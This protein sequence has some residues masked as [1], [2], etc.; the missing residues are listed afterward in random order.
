M[1]DKTLTVSNTKLNAT[2][3][4]YTVSWNKAN[5][6]GTPQ[7]NLRY[8]FYA[9]GSSDYL[10]MAIRGICIPASV[11]YP[12]TGICYGSEG[13]Q[14][15]SKHGEGGLMHVGKLDTNSVS[16]AWYYLTDGSIYVTVFVFN[17]NNCSMRYDDI[18]IAIK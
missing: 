13:H 8:H 17:E 9:E 1:S 18:V 16:D 11:R 14:L 6:A 3:F 7:S 15:G 10:D 12:T 4:E 5:D 2:N